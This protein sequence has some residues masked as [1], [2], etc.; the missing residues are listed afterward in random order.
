MH[1]LLFASIVVV[2]AII[3]VSSFMAFRKT[4]Q[5]QAV[6]EPAHAVL[7][8]TTT[9]A[10]TITVVSLKESATA[11]SDQ[12]RVTIRINITNNDAKPL[13]VSPGLQFTLS[14]SD[15][16]LSSVT[17]EYI[18]TGQVIGGPITP[19]TTQTMD[20]D[21]NVSSTAVP[22]QLIFTTD[23]QTESLQVRLR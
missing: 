18:A 23:A 11:S 8:A 16:I 4:S 3:S 7:G 20:L 22:D 13:L 10:T 12:K 1:R 5:R 17:T 14:S 6:P 21:F 19:K 9:N 15:K 2:T